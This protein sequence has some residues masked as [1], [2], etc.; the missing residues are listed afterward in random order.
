MPSA[1]AFLF[2]P[3]NARAGSVE[4]VSAQ[5]RVGGGAW[6]ASLFVENLLNSKDEV[7]RT[8]DSP[9]APTFRRQGLRPRTIGVQFI[10]KR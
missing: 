3:L 8:H 2:D 1:P 6:E 4:F 9:F 10:V 7:F 5:A